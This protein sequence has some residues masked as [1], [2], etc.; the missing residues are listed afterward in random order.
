[1]VDRALKNEDVVED[2]ERGIILPLVRE[3]EDEVEE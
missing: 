3:E 2:E 1:V